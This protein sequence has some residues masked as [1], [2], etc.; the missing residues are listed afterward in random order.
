MDLSFIIKSIPPL[1]HGALITI[2]LS[3][4]SLL[5]GAVIALFIVIMRLMG[6]GV[7]RIL[8]STIV[9][10]VRGT[11]LLVQLYLVYYGLPQIGIV[12]QA[13]IVAIVVLSFYMGAYL[14]E[15]LRGAI[16]SIHYSQIEGAISLG[17]SRWQALRIVVLPQAFRLTIPPSA[18]QFIS[19]L[20]E[21]SLVSQIAIM[22]LT[23]TATWIISWTFRAFETYILAALVYLLITTL[24][25]LF[26]GWL[27]KRTAIPGT[28]INNRES[29]SKELQDAKSLT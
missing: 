8:A 7:F 2:I 26:A 18:N 22:E 1:I 27:E 29:L 11:P 24:F 20:K 14:S 15:A 17:L 19:M 16:E 6:G 9:G 4:I 25:T 12:L 28:E 3:V 5:F 13:Y 21:S 23:L 10:A